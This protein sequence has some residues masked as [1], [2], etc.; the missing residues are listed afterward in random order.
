MSMNAML[1]GAVSGTAATLPM[2]A[3]MVAAQ[4]AGLMGRHPPELITEQAFSSADIEPSKRSHAIASATAHVGFGMAAG[5]LYGVFAR[6][7]GSPAPPVL[8]GIAY[9]LLV[10]GLSYRGWIPAV[11]VMPHADHDRRDRQASMIAAHVVYGAVLG[12][13]VG[14]RED[15]GGERRGDAAA[16][17][18]VDRAET[19]F[20]GHAARRMEAEGVSTQRK[21]GFDA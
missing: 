20:A 3:V 11:G 18:G 8:Q 4:R 19:P 5:S 9:G 15:G 13:L 12:A 16:A 21:G 6:R 2:S 10:Y 14:G 7:I 1:R 17:K